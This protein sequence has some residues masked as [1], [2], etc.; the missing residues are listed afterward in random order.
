LVN[1]VV[2][3]SATDTAKTRVIND[4]EAS[5]NNGWS[6]AK[7]ILEACT[8]LADKALADDPTWAATVKQFQNQLS[9]A[10]YFTEVRAVDTTDL[11]RLQGVLAPITPF[12]DLSTEDKIVQIIGTV[13]PG[14]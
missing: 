13:P 7:V 8:S 12:T 5:L 11:A 2:K 10:R 4:F 6:R 3:T 14:G 1:R 9:V